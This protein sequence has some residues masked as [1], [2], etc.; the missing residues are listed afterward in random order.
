MDRV[1]PEQRSWIMSRIRGRNTGPEMRVRR[2]AH[3]MGYRYR[4]HRKDLPGCPDM[5]FKSR[6]K[7][8]FVHGCFWHLHEGCRLN[9]KPK[10]RTA[11]WHAKL[12]RNKARDQENLRRLE[13]AGWEVLV[14]WECE[15]E[16][17]MFIEKRLQGFLES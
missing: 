2:L 4:V 16:D 11:Y 3:A 9:R 7:I 1:S 5:V 13:E 12:E 6:R 10:S 15:T 14:I 17:L 8:I